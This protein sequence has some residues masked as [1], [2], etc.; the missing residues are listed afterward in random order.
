MFF[1]LAHACSRFKCVRWWP[2]V[3]LPQFV[4]ADAPAWIR[5]F[6][7]RASISC[8]SFSSAFFLPCQPFL[9]QSLSMASA[10]LLTFV[11][12]LFLICSPLRNPSDE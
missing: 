2:T 12:V 1:D 7:T 9:I 4:V 3:S 10:V 8:F 5:N 11:S 6:S